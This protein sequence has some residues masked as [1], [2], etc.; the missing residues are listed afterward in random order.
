MNFMV[1][2]YALLKLLLET[3]YF[4]LKSD[5]KNYTVYIIKHPNYWG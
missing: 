1:K 3:K 4:A 5:I 2:L